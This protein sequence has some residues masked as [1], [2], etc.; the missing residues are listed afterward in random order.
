MEIL[1]Y[2][3]WPKLLKSLT[4]IARYLY[5]KRVTPS[6]FTDITRGPTN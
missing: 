2:H 4:K 5:L 6:V 3:D 1:L